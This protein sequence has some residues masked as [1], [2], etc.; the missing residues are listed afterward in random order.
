MLT[1]Y[2]EVV[3]KSRDKFMRFPVEESIAYREKFLHLPVVNAFIDLFSEC[4]KV[5]LNKTGF[6]LPKKP[7]YP[8]NKE[9]AVCVTHD[10]DN[11]NKSVALQI[12]DTLLSNSPH[13]IKRVLDLLK[14]PFNKLDLSWTLEYAMNLERIQGIKPSFFFMADGARY[15]L[16]S[17]TF[18]NTVKKI[19]KNDFEVGLHPA[20]KTSINRKKIYAL[21]NSLMCSAAHNIQG[22]RQHYLQI[23]IPE[24]WQIFSETALAYD[25]SLGFAGHEGFQS[26]ILPSFSAL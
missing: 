18:K 26:R 22:V 25:T 16:E 5:A 7:L 17:P 14:N 8:E 1:R 6:E 11:L 9:F 19:L 23:E 2:E 13:K 20:L 10:I 3:S 12:K 15:S 21:L 24:T 4:I